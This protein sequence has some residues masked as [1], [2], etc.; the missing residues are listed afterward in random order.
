MLEVIE[1]AE[2]QKD[3]CRVW[4]CRCDCEKELLVSAKSLVSGHVKSCGCLARPPLKELVGRRFGILEVVD[5]E[6][7]RSG[8]HRWRCRCDCGKETIVGQTLLQSGKTRSCGCL[9]AE[10]YQKNLKL[11]EGTS[12]AVLE[13]QRKKPSKANTSGHTG[14]YLDKRSGR[15]VAQIRLKGKAYYLGSYTKIEDAIKA[16]ERGEIIHEECIEDY[17]RAQQKAPGTDK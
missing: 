9:Q 15:W 7:K 5:Y 17:Y 16:R 4:R 10:S 1:A 11:F 14:V 3:K 8:M 2:Q 6:G 13:A 12:I